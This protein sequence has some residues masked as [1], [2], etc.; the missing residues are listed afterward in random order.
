MTDKVRLLLRR[1]A[2]EI[3]GI[4]GGSLDRIILYGSLARG[5]D[6]ADSDIDLMI[7]VQLSDE[8]I[9]A[10]MSAVA[11]LSFDMEMEYD[12]ILSPIIKNT[13]QFMDWADT[14]PFYRNV[15]EEGVEL[16]AE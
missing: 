5:E 14:V 16:F 4:F 13:D 1:Y 11:S 15:M 8:E 2:E 6:T 9:K 7:L 3:R 12:V 10:Y